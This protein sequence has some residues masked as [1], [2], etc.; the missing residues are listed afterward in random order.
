MKVVQK[1][2]FV[3]LSVLLLLA[4]CGQDGNTSSQSITQTNHPR[5]TARGTAYDTDHMNDS[6]GFARYDRSEVEEDNEHG[7]AMAFD[8]DMLADGISRLVLTNEEIEQA[9]TLITDKYALV[10]YSA[11][12]EEKSE[13]LAADQ[14]KRTALSALPSYYQVYVADDHEMVDDIERYQT[15]S[16]NNNDYAN[17]IEE[18]IEEMK[19]HPQ[20]NVEEDKDR[21]MNI[22]RKK[23]QELENN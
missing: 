1:P 11:D 9:A 18:T 19:Q 14:V 7:L 3:V 6:F 4:G 10:V 12:H 20:G 15:L 5:Q 22:M 2:L 21:D 8:R 17:M 23:H 16:S 13:E